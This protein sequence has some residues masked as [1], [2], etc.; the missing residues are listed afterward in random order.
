MPKSYLCIGN[1]A[2]E[3]FESKPTNSLFPKDLPNGSVLEVVDVTS[4]PK[5]FL[6]SVRVGDE[7]DLSTFICPRKQF[8]TPIKA[9]CILVKDDF[10]FS[11][12]D[13]KNVSPLEI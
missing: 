10:M 8:S 13:S 7:N 5:F 1:V 11:P 2:K 12:W 9:P 3:E 6:L 4:I